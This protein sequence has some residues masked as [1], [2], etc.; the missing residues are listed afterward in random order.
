[1]L[2]TYRFTAIDEFNFYHSRFQEQAADYLDR[3]S[4]TL[5]TIEIVAIAS[6]TEICIFSSIA[7]NNLKFKRQIARNY[8]DRVHQRK[9]LP[10]SQPVLVKRHY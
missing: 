8:L 9:R 10:K 1:M 5:K 4:V 2:N 3:S 6:Y 7:A